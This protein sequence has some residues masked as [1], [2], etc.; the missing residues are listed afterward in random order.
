MIDKKR[1]GRPRSQKS[2]VAYEQI[3]NDIEIGLFKSGDILGTCGVLSE[4][5]NIARNTFCS[6]IDKLI[7]EGIIEKVK[8]LYYYK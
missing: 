1:A 6:L 8:T 5:Y 2:L 4:K 7:N 3:K